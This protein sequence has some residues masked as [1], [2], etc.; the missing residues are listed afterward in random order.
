MLA[1]SCPMS[2][3]SYFEVGMRG[4]ELTV[5]GDETGSHEGGN[6]VDVAAGTE[7]AVVASQAAR[8]PDGVGGAES[9][10]DLGFHLLASPPWITTRVELHGLGEQDGARTIDVETPAFVG[11]RRVLH[12]GVA[13]APDVARQK[14]IMF[15]GGPGLRAP[16]VE[17]PVDRTQLSTA[18]G[19]CGP[20]VA[21]PRVV[22][23]AFNNR[24]AR[25]GHRG[26][27]RALVDLGNQRDWFVAR[28]GVR[29]VGPRSSRGA[30]GV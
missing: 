12:F 27:H 22:E 21:H 23:W 7:L 1:R 2:S 26:R 5:G 13:L 28:D 10:V 29:H 18:R 3:L 4:V 16:T 9:G 24:D 14:S 19:E 11:E 8:E 30:Q 17:D 20:D 6:D 25:T 15:P